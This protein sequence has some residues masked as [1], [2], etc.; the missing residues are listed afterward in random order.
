MRKVTFPPKTSQ[1]VETEA[2]W[3]AIRAKVVN[4]ITLLRPVVKE[5]PFDDNAV[6]EVLVLLLHQA[7]DESVALFSLAGLLFEV[8]KGENSVHSL[9]EVPFLGHDHEEEQIYEVVG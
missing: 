9:L 8:T 2:D 4:N 5:E 7:A 3:D 1:L 6:E